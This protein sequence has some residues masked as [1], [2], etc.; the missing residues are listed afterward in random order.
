MASGPSGQ[1]SPAPGSRVHEMAGQ[2]QQDR[3]REAVLG[4]FDGGGQDVVEGQPPVAI[5]QREPAVDGARHRHAADVAPHGHRRHAVAAQ[6]GRVGCRAGPARRRGVPRGS[7]PVAPPWPARHRRARTG[8]AP[9][10]PSPSPWRRRRRRPSRPAPACR[11]PPRPPA[12][13]PPPPCRAGPCADR[14]GQEGG[15]CLRNSTIPLSAEYGVA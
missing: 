3:R 12:G 2:R 5:V 13:R 14:K 11:A 9:R 4:Q 7:T 1:S 6:P 15:T 8:A 10:P